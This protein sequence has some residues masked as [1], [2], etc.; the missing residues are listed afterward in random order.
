MNTTRYDDAAS[1]AAST[2]PGEHIP[3]LPTGGALFLWVAG[4]MAAAVLLLFGGMIG[5][6]I[7]QAVSGAG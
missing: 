6:G 1:A 2:P 3:G 5:L 7:L 4:I